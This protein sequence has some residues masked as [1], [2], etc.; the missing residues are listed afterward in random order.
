MKSI[1]DEKSDESK[2]NSMILILIGGILWGIAVATSNTFSP[3][4]ISATYD[5]HHTSAYI[6]SIYNVYKHT[7]FHGGIT[8]QYGHYGL[9]FY[10]PLKIFG[11]STKTIAGVCGVLSGATYIFAMSSF[12]RIVKSNVLR[13]LVIIVGGMYAIYP[14][15][16]SIY[17]QLYPHRVLFPAITIFLSTVFLR[18]EVNVWKKCGAISVMTLAVIWNLETGVICCLAWAAFRGLDVLQNE[19]ISIKSTAKIIGRVVCVVMIPLIGA[20]SIVNLYN[21][22]C[23]GVE[24]WLGAKEFAGMVVDNGYITS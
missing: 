11:F 21:L 20:Y 12:C 4:A 22:S 5:V 15:I 10:L 13:Y 1:R 9:F 8:D 14:A 7:E 3:A 17:W 19:A 2:F 16:G 6:D 24:A 18:S 23:G